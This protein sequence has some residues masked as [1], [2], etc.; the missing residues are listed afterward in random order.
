MNVS[1]K[2]SKRSHKHAFR[3]L[4]IAP[5]FYPF[6]SGG[7]EIASYNLTEELIKKGNKV[8]VITSKKDKNVIETPP[9]SSQVYL[10]NT[11]NIPL[12]RGVIFIIKLFNHMLALKDKIDLIHA[13]TVNM[14][15]IAGIFGKVINRPVISWARGAD[16]YNHFGSLHFRF[17]LKWL[18][19]NV[20]II[21]LTQD[22][23]K[24]MRQIITPSR[25]NV[26]PNGVHVQRK[27]YSK[28]KLIRKLKID[29][30][31]F[32]IKLILYVGRLISF[33]GLTYLI[34]SVPLILAKNPE[35]YFLI[36]G[37][38]PQKRDL[39][40]LCR[41]LNIMAHFRFIN[42]LTQEWV[43][44]FMNCVDIFVY[45]TL[46]GQ[47][48][49]NAVLEAMASKL[50]VVAT[51]VGGLPEII[52][53]GKNGLLVPSRDV[54]RLASTISMLLSNESLCKKLGLKARKKAIERYCWS[55]I[56]D[57]LLNVYIDLIRD[58]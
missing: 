31:I 27:D 12:L 23:K 29:Q 46:R 28:V 50:P 16:I 4:F 53:N 45:P 5:R 47:G 42:N 15:F 44:R 38:G 33:K 48:M 30:D 21:A 35:A 57:K 22:L 2:L 34:K 11:T 1:R 40:R 54:D 49:S 24:K 36:V 7:T 55:I 41:Q 9:I 51:N 43:S 13:Q 3:I 58:D 20:R 8:F 19:N 10:I 18:K 37:N 25:I 32:S 14:G 39:I 6:C 26:I 52:S 56:T 17:I